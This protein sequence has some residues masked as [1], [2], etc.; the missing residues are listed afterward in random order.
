MTRA[1]SW[2]AVVRGLLLVWVLAAVQALLPRPVAAM[3]L[4]ARQTGQPCAACHTSPP[5]LTPFGRRFMLGAYT[6]TG[7]VPGLPLSGYL[8]L[9]ATR[10]G[11]D[12]RVRLQ[13]AKLIGGGAL[14]DHVGAYAELVHGPQAGGLR[15]G[16]V[17]LRVADSTTL[18][19]HDLVHGMS[20]NNAPGS[21]DPWN[22]SPARSWP[23]ARTT[24][25]PQPRYQAL[26]EGPLA[27]RSAGAS[28]YGLLDDA[29][30]GELGAYG[31]IPPA[32]QRRLGGDPGTQP[33]I[34]GTAMMGRLAHERR[35]SSGSLTVGASTLV[36]RMD[37]SAG[38][39][40]ASSRVRMLGLDLLWQQRQ[41]QHEGT[42][43]VS[44]SR[45]DWQDAGRPGGTNRLDSLKASA[46]YLHAK[47]KALTLGHF[48]HIGRAD[49]LFWQTASGKPDSAG[50]QLDAY[51]INPFFAP[52]RWHPGMRTRLGAT[53][54]HHTVFDGDADRAADRDTLFIYFL[55]AL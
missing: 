26:L 23:F 17:D 55:W 43:R 27:Q 24:V 2:A 8:E 45:E 47:D 49:G 30:Y 1:P 39:T 28:V 12:D 52:P 6:M 48:R 44:T 50:V 46:T 31:G 51:L 19:G 3:P 41:G 18:A 20:V 54:T 29:W 5:E 21:Q 15:L 25:G 34:L 4:F 40:V 36:S 10:S 53:L 11:S 9:G 22:S 38:A 42:V 35:L 33:H 32:T 13:R 7:G 16:R 37:R 14:T